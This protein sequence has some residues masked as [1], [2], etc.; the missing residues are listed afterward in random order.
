M[1]G[2]SALITPRMISAHELSP[3]EN[4][5]PL[6]PVEFNRGPRFFRDFFLLGAPPLTNHP[7]SICTMRHL[8]THPPHRLGLGPRPFGRVCFPTHTGAP[9]LVSI[10]WNIFRVF[11][12]KPNT[13]AGICPGTRSFG[14]S[15]LLAQLNSIIFCG[16]DKS[17]PF[18]LMET[19]APRWCSGLRGCA[20]RPIFCVSQVRDTGKAK[21]F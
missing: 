14:A 2:G 16:M 6:P 19:T 12:F 15:V 10:R 11:L 21:P 5:A 9:P 13:P 3:Q 8:P 4:L 7:T 20:S 17:H 18:S 1:E